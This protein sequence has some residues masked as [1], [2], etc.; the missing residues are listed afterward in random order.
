MARVW[1][2]VKD[3][4]RGGTRTRD[5]EVLGVGRRGGGGGIHAMRGSSW[6][7]DN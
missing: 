6:G 7:D 4:V 5:M 1:V 3:G 2:T